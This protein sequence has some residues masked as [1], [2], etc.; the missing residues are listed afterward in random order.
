MLAYRRLVGVGN[1][2]QHAD[3]AHRQLGAEVFD[4]V[5]PVT[6][7][8]HVQAGHA[9]RPDLVLEGAHLLGREGPCGESPVDG[10]QGRI[11]VDENP[12]RHDRIGLDHIEDVA[13]G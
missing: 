3:G 11:L 5:E 7:G 13:L 9:E 10:V 2:E 4:E 12:R 1:T 6:V 8:D